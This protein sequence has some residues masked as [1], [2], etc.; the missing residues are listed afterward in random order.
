MMSMRSEFGEAAKVFLRACM[1][2]CKIWGL[3]LCGI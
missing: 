1:V 3:I 2:Q